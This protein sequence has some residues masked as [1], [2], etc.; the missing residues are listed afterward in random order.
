[1]AMRPESYIDVP[2]PEMT[3]PW[4]HEKRRAYLPSGYRPRGCWLCHEV[5]D[6]RGADALVMFAFGVPVVCHRS[7]GN[8]PELWGG[9]DQRKW[10]M[11]AAEA[12]IWE[13]FPAARPFDIPDGFYERISKG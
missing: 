6:L 9:D 13:A 12:V 4:I 3:D 5:C 2:R 1:M 8:R 7:C 10:A 11:L